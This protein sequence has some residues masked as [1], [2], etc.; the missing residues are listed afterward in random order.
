MSQQSHSMTSSRP[1]TVISSS[2]TYERRIWRGV[3]V[4]FPRRSFQRSSHSFSMESRSPADYRVSCTFQDR[5][6]W[7]ACHSVLPRDPPVCMPRTE[8]LGERVAGCDPGGQFDH[9]HEEY[10]HHGP[11]RVKGRGMAGSGR[12]VSGH[13]RSGRE[14]DRYGR[15]R[16]RESLHHEECRHDRH[17]CR[18]VSPVLS[19]SSHQGV[20]LGEL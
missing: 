17:G 15:H 13:H 5:S 2:S 4:G 11:Y 19:R 6:R 10:G 3:W 14:C 8:R 9:G 18:R 12:H 20:V 1:A 16:E 7:R